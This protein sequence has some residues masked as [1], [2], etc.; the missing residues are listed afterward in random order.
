VASIRV[1]SRNI[2]EENLSRPVVGAHILSPECKISSQILGRKCGRAQ[3]F[4]DDSNYNFIHEGITRTLHFLG[5][6]MDRLQWPR[7]VLHEMSSP[8]RTL[9]SWVRIPLEA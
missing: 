9:G 7:F 2:C 3:V 5:G 1:W 8:A 4:G 6:E